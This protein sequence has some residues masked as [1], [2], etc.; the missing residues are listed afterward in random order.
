MEPIFAET[1]GETVTLKLCA[2]L[3]AAI[4]MLPPTHCWALTKNKPTDSQRADL[5]RLQDWAFTKGFAF[6]IESTKTHKG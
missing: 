5:I 3:D 6:V 2:Q 1:A 4:A